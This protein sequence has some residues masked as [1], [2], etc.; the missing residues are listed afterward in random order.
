MGSIMFGKYTSFSSNKRPTYTHYI[1]GNIF[2]HDSSGSHNGIVAD[3]DSLQDGGIGAY[4]Y[5]LAQNDGGGVG[6]AAVFRQEAVVECGKDDVM[7]YLATVTQ[8]H[9]AM[10]LEVA[11]GIDEH[12]FAHRDVF[13]EV[14]IKGRKDPERIGYRLAEQ[15]G[16]QGPYF[17][18]SMIG[19]VQPEGDASG[20]VAHVVHQAMNGFGVECLAG[21]HIR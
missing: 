9:T 13:P 16:K 5:I 10:V 1:I 19:R 4:P 20:F 15:F 18:G 11:A 12:V 8:R 14:R 6:S 7:A 17:F 3:G 2:G 21:L